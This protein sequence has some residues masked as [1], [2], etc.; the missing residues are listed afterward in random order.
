[1]HRAHLANHFNHKKL[2]SDNTLYVIGV[3]SNSARFHSRYRLARQ[4]IAHM[5]KTPNIQL[6]IVEVAYGDHKFEITEKNNPWHLQL[7]SRTSMWLKENMIN[8]G[9][10]HLLPH[11]WKYMAW[12]DMDVF[13]EDKEHWAQDCLHELQRFHVVQ[14]WS[15]CIDLGP[16]GNILTHFRSFGHQHQN[17]IPK[18]THH[19]QPY[20]VA[21]PG[22]AWACTREFYENLPGGLMWFPPL[23]SADFHMAF[24]C[25]GEVEKTIYG[26]LTK[27]FHR[28]CHEWQS[29]A[30]RITNHQVGYI[31]GFIKHGFHGPKARRYYLDRVKLLAKYGYDPDKHIKWDY[32]GLPFLFNCPGLEH[33]MHRY[34]LSRHEDS[35]E[36][37]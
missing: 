28:L 11:D 23:G 21:H 5:L 14:P 9:V 36:E 18:Q 12:I 4:W 3:V 37:S 17:K 30:I 6:A 19:K 31:S 16:T 8:C 22:F 27:S 10:R 15:D 2:N 33:E 7:R 32:Q 34:N 35:I 29:R 1:M 20:E 13:F 24:A 26:G 25:I